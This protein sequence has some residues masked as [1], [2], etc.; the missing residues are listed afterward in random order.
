MLI[1]DSF[2]SLHPKAV[3]N[4]MEPLKIQDMRKHPSEW[5]S[6]RK[7]A[8]AQ[9]VKEVFSSLVGMR[10]APRNPSNDAQ[11]EPL[12]V[13]LEGSLSTQA[14]TVRAAPRRPEE[15]PRWS[16]NPGPRQG[17]EDTVTQGPLAQLEGIP[18]GREEMSPLQ[19]PEPLLES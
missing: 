12:T 17:V 14:S 15:G 9:L 16:E 7:P 8:L 18:S 13:T 19:L 10:E 4:F 5:L 1:S 2:T 6:L 3:C 11:S